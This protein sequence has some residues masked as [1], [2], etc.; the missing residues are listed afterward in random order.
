[1]IIKAKNFLL[2]YLLFDL[3]FI[4]QSSLSQ[5]NDLT[6]L[7]SKIWNL[8]IVIA[9]K[10]EEIKEKF[11][12]YFKKEISEI[13][14]INLTN[15]NVDYKISITAIEV[16]MQAKT[17]GKNIERILFAS[18][19]ITQKINENL[20]NKIVADTSI[21]KANIERIRK[22]ILKAEIIKSQLAV[23]GSFD[24]IQDF[25]KEIMNDMNKNIFKR[26][27]N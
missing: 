4:S 21:F 13:G 26:R 3:I 12:K 5:S 23:M 9:S 15:K 6:T 18:I 25:C 27:K 20:F 10:S 7:S 22:S 14:G 16:P 8:E 19:V 24:D 2:T 1:M 17:R 11:L